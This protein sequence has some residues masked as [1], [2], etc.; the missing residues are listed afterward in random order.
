MVS[1]RIDQEKCVSAGRCV[2]DEPA[3]FAFD[4]HE[5]AIVQPGV[6]D[7]S[8]E[9]LIVIARRCPGLAIEVLA[10]DGTVLAP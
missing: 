8:Q 10:E 9:R 2:A 1:V 5:L 3:A 7:L 4:D 6:S